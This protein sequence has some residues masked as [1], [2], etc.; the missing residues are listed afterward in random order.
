MDEST[1]TDL[2][3]LSEYPVAMPTVAGDA[4]PATEGTTI[5]DEDHRTNT[6]GDHLVSSPNLSPA[7]ISTPEPV[8]AVN[9]STVP[10]P[11]ADM[12]REVA[13]QWTDP[14]LLPNSEARLASVRELA[15]RATDSYISQ[16]IDSVSTRELCN[17]L[18]RLLDACIQT[19]GRSSGAYIEARAVWYNYDDPSSA[20]LSET[21]EFDISLEEAQD[22]MGYFVDRIFDGVGQH[23]ERRQ[24]NLYPTIYTVPQANGRPMLPP[25]HP[26]VAQRAH[27][28]ERWFC[29]LRD[30]QG[31]PPIGWDEVSR[32]M[33]A[34]ENQFFSLSRTPGG[35]LPWG[36][37]LVDWEAFE[38]NRVYT[39]IRTHQTRLLAGDPYA[40]L[41]AF[42]WIEIDADEPFRLFPADP[43][44]DFY[45]M[46]ET[47]YSLATLTH[48]FDDNAYLPISDEPRR[49]FTRQFVE[50]SQS[51]LT[52]QI[53]TFLYYIE[54]NERLSPPLRRRQASD[55]PMLL[56]MPT[57]IIDVIFFINNFI[58][59]LAVYDQLHDDHDEFNVR[60]VYKFIVKNRAF[61]IDGGV[62]GG[63]E[64][65][66]CVGLYMLVMGKFIQD[67]HER[68]KERKVEPHRMRWNYNEGY[69]LISIMNTLIEGIKNTSRPTNRP[70]VSEGLASHRW[71][72]KALIF[73]REGEPTSHRVEWP[74]G[75]WGKDPAPAEDSSE[76]VTSRRPEK[77]PSPA[78]KDRKGKKKEVDSGPGKSTVQPAG[79]LDRAD[80]STPKQG[81]PRVLPG[82]EPEVLQLPD[83]E[84]DDLHKG[85]PEPESPPA[86][87]TK[88]ESIPNP[89]M[90]PPSISVP[91]SSQTIK[92]PFT[93]QTKPTDLPP[94]VEESRRRSLSL[95]AGSRPLSRDPEGM[96]LGLVVEPL[97]DEPNTIGAPADTSTP[98]PRGRPLV[99]DRSR[100]SAQAEPPAAS[101][102]TSAT[103]KRPPVKPAPSS[104]SQVAG[105]ASV[106]GPSTLRATSSSKSPAL[107]GKAAPLPSSTTRAIA[108]A[109]PAL[110]SDDQVASSMLGAFAQSGSGSGSQ[111]IN[112]RS[113]P[114]AA[115]AN[116]T[117]R[118]LK[119]N[120][121][122][123]HGSSEDEAANKK[124]ESKKSRSASR[125]SQR[126]K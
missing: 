55:P 88:H 5:A 9:E 1:L 62:A 125:H 24:F 25:P 74:F 4:S 3:A 107:G 73:Q 42:Q 100:H 96:G 18:P 112:Y 124:P 31:L 115:A 111:R 49:W 19:L 51:F 10:E 6:S 26:S 118:P 68:S 114:R 103:R 35:S 67:E 93:V 40:K 12:Q 80:G 95:S 76:P 90:P 98:N 61:C 84:D 102:A 37:P 78:P 54:L 94:V 89:F 81:I 66:Y 45:R 22:E 46:E 117:R 105:E 53:R 59:P 69:N 85:Y 56:L 21:A 75:A 106:P 99:R 36:R 23:F 104:L 119:R 65:V 113:E 92:R 64:G 17:Q 48:F 77:L 82:V 120:V 70:E 87:E 52:S 50:Q 110:S 7:V 101:K 39:H 2:T 126:E 63:E 27:T 29:A 20:T 47:A 57:G 97:P 34:H 108:A 11:D 83:S 33:S 8:Q 71:Q 43:T 16:G 123:P 79:S 41:T 28:L 58:M 15:E 30:W 122:R 109:T 116:T 38:I 14:N 121:K 32:G 72:P 60:A 86:E 91:S 13:I 44:A